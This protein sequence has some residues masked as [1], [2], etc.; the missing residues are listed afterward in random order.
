MIGVS[1]FLTNENNQVGT[2]D[3][4]LKW[5]GVGGRKE[6]EYNAEHY[7]PYT[8]TCICSHI[9]VPYTVSA[10]YDKLWFFC[11]NITSY[12]FFLSH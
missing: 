12:T 4:G 11:N 10:Y 5:R 8:Y 6:G 1:Y 9:I 3:R 7:C 2:Y